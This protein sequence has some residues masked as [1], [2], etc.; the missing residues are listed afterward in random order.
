M[1]VYIYVY[2]MYVCEYTHTH[3]HTHT[4]NIHASMYNIERGSVGT[5]EEDEFRA[6][7]NDTIY[8]PAS[9]ACGLKL[10]AYVALSY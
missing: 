8:T 5:V 2:N 10:L 7:L 3:T 6:F 4:Y 1:Y 9:S